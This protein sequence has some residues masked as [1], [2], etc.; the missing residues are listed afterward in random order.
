MGRVVPLE[1]LA[2]AVAAER[3]AGRRIVLTNGCFDL[4]HVGHVR[5]LQACRRLGDVLVVGVNAD[6][7]VRRLKGPGR[8]YVPAAER[9]E[10]LAALGAVDLVAVFPEPTAERL[11]ALVRP[12]VYAKGA[13]YARGGPGGP[14]GAEIDAARL[15]EAA[16]VRSH[17]GQV[18]LLPLVQSRSSSGLAARIA[19]AHAAPTG[20]PP[21]PA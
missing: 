16:V 12:D 15:P 13:D 21:E 8:P 10:V 17:G 5:A 18:V 6:D 20:M 11:A 14:R 7:S 19:A 1:L 9:A 4:L 2:E 3:A